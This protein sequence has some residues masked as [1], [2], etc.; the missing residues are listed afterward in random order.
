MLK[1]TLAVV[2]VVGTFILFSTLNLG[3]TLAANQRLYTRPCL[4]TDCGSGFV[5]IDN[6]SDSFEFKGDGYR[7]GQIISVTF[8]D[9]N[10]ATVEDDV[11]V[12]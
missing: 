9:N 1:N 3:N 4:V 7:M 12:G 6:G 2:G 11:I 8:C 10:T 5:T